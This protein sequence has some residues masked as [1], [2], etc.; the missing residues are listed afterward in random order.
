MLFLVKEGYL[1][2]DQ[3]ILKKSTEYISR[4]QSLR[5]FMKFNA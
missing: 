5:G 4:R 2:K 1:F 3:I